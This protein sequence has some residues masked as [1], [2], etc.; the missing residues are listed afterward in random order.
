LKET[1]Q[2]ILIKRF[3]SILDSDNFSKTTDKQKKKQT[4]KRIIC[5][6]SMMMKM[7][8]HSENENE[9][10][11]Q[12]QIEENILLVCNKFYTK[13]RIQREM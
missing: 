9:R 12:N 4:I 6:L 13:S 5:K 8:L 2:Q 1:R 3:G 7:K 10:D 11:Y